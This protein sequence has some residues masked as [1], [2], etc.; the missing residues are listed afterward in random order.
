MLRDKHVQA[1]IIFGRGKPQNGI[2]IDPKDGFR[3]DD[4]DTEAREAFKDMIW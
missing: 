4:N 1:A 2:L 3:V